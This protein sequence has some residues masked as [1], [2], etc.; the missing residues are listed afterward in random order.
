MKMAALELDKLPLVGRDFWRLQIYVDQSVP[1]RLPEV[2]SADLQAAWAEVLKRMKLTQHHKITREEL[3]VRDHMSHILRQLQNTRF[4]EF[5]ELFT[6]N[7]KLISA[8]PAVV[9]VHFIA[10]LELAKESLLE[11]TQAQPF[12]PIYVRLAYRPH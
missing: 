10:L 2:N 4:V 8:G 7:P 12:A 6:G 3:S 5:T 11:I 1:V 9:V